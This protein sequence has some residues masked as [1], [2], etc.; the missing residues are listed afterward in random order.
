M[1]SKNKPLSDKDLETYE[2]SRDIAADLIQSIREMKAGLGTV[3]YSPTAEARKKVAMT[4]LE[5]AT[6]LDISVETLHV[7]EH[8]LEQQPSGPARELIAMALNTPEA[9][10]KLVR[11]KP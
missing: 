4:E 6:A 7:W 1:Q 2:A 11:F 8:G 10:L 3:V 5:F 9:F